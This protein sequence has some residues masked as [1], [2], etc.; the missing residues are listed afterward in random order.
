MREPSLGPIGATRRAAP[1]PPAFHPPLIHSHQ[2]DVVIFQVVRHWGWCVGGRATWR[3][4]KD[5]RKKRAQVWSERF[6]SKTEPRRVLRLN[7]LFTRAP[8]HTRLH[9]P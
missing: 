3:G 4:E 1:L 7:P 8:A 2:L 5:G 9:W 6:P